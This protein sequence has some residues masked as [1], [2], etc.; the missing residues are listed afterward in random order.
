MAYLAFLALLLSFAIV[1]NEIMK[2]ASQHQEGKSICCRVCGRSMGQ[3]PIHWS[4]Q[5]P[6][7]IWA[8]VAKYNLSPNTVKRFLCPEKHTQ[9][10]YVP[11]LGDRRCDVLVTK[12]LKVN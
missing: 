6:F 8:V 3:V 10:W 2:K 12:D 11:T 9:A 7:E 1:L 4:Y 5:L